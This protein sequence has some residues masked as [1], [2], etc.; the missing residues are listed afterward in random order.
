[1]EKVNPP[2]NKSK[3]IHII[4]TKNSQRFKIKLILPQSERFLGSLDTSGEVHF[5]TA[6]K[7]EH[8]YRRY[9]SFGINYDLI[10]DDRIEFKWI[11]IKCDS[12]EYVTTREYV[13]KK[14][15]PTSYRKKGFE[16]QLHVPL[17]ELNNETIQEFEQ[18]M[19]FQFSFFDKDEDWGNYANA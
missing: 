1:M 5:V 3:D 4:P 6:R 16:L 10:Y 14:G 2:A 8:I 7:P 12:K 17:D 19:P 13:K 18:V 9:N 11:I 15:K